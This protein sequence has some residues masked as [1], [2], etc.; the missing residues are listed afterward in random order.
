MGVPL[1]D[2][3]LYY[4]GR[5]LKEPPE[6]AD[7][8][9]TANYICDFYHQLLAGYKPPNTARICIHAGNEKAW[10]GVQYHGSICSIAATID[11]TKYLSLGKQQQLEY[12]LGLIHGVCLELCDTQ[13]WDKLIF[14]RAYHQIVDLDYQ[15]SLAYPYKRSRDRQTSARIIIEKTIRH[16][17]LNMEWTGPGGYEKVNLLTKKNWFGNDSVYKLAKRSK[18]LDKTAFGVSTASN[19]KYA[20]YSILDKVIIGNL[21]FNDNEF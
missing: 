4:F 11:E 18:W 21:H 5:A 7:F 13:Q 9:I 14:E 20:Y 3:T 16:S 1:Y 10:N 12:L 17:F 8:R 6:E 15:F 2:I 19:D